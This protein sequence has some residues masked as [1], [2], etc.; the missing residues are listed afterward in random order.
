MTTLTF[1][2]TN[3]HERNACVW[4]DTGI[5]ERWVVHLLCGV[6]SFSI[7]FP[8]VYKSFDATVQTIVLEL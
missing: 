5:P 2:R 6:D 7:L 3:Q 8:K 4:I 1:Y